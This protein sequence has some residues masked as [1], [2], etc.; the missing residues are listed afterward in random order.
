[1]CESAAAACES[2]GGAS[3]APRESAA[4][5]CAAAASTMSTKTTQLVRID[6][7]EGWNRFGLRSGPVVQEIGTFAAPPRAVFAA[8]RQPRG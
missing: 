6:Y 4:H 2:G 3:G 5:G 1:V 8:R 7:S